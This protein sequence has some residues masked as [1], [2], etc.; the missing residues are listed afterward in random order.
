MAVRVGFGSCRLLSRSKLLRFARVG[1]LA[2]FTGFIVQKPVQVTVPTRARV[3]SLSKLGFSLLFLVPWL[4]S[5]G[6]LRQIEPI[7]PTPATTREALAARNA[8]F[9]PAPGNCHGSV[10]LHPHRHWDRKA[11]TL[12]VLAEVSEYAM[13]LLR[14]SASLSVELRGDLR[15]QPGE[16]CEDGPPPG[17]HGGHRQVERDRQFCIRAAQSSF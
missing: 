13:T 16:T 6:H 9:H 5:F 1:R 15:F 17:F 4:P 12:L 2:P 14:T 7:W 10:K 11:A 8:E 3:A